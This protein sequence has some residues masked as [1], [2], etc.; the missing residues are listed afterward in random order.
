MVVNMVGGMIFF[1]HLKLHHYMHH[2]SFAFRELMLITPAF[3]ILTSDVCVFQVS[4]VKLDSMSRR[5]EEFKSEEQ[6]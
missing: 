6:I 5:R 3:K 4:S 1:F 2:M